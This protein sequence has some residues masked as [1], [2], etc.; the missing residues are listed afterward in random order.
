MPQRKRKTRKIYKGGNPPTVHGLIS[1]AAQEKQLYQS[2]P[3]VKNELRNAWAKGVQ[4]REQNRAK[5]IAEMT[6]LERR[7]LARNNTPQFTF[8]NKRNKIKKTP[9]EKL[10]NIMRT[11]EEGIYQ[12][13]FYTQMSPAI[14][15]ATKTQNRQK[16]NLKLLGKLTFKNPKV[17]FS[18]QTENRARANKKI[19]EERME[20]NRRQKII[21]GYLGQNYEPLAPT[22]ANIVKKELARMIEPAG[23][24]LVNKDSEGSGNNYQKDPTTG[25][26]IKTVKTQ[27]INKLSNWELGT[28]DDTEYF[29]HNKVT[30]ETQWELNGW[31]VASVI[32][33]LP[34]FIN[35]STGETSTTLLD[36]KEGLN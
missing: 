26:W 32:N 17:P 11:Y 16:E 22:R 13:P 2:P 7:L 33:G 10:N 31:E 6:P 24:L 27:T 18:F 8:I 30:D 34:T 5:K 12:D 14:L 29:F 23:K 19:L 15:T 1:A 28:V 4:Q 25:R 21:K 35:K 9:E 36:Q 20:E 3:V